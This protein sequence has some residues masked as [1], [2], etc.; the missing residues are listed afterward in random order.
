[1]EIESESAI[2]LT[3]LVLNDWKWPIASPLMQAFDR[4]WILVVTRG[5]LWLY[6]NC[7]HVS[8]GQ[9]HSITS[10]SSLV[11]INRSFICKSNI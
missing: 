8:I 4:K 9:G 11:S 2:V 3:W 1:M 6:T 5:K 10:N 7:F